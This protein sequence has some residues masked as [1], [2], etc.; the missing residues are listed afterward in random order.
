MQKQSIIPII[1]NITIINS[2]YTIYWIYNILCVYVCVRESQREKKSIVLSET[3]ERRILR[4]ERE[5]EWE[6]KKVRILL[7][8]YE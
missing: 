7:S 3:R 8:A 6:K 2:K 4:D 1:D 5:R